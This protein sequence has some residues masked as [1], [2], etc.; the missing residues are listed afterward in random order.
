MN[1]QMTKQ[2]SKKVVKKK[3]ARYEYWFCFVDRNNKMQST[4]ADC[5]CLIN[6]REA[7][8][9]AQAEIEHIVNGNFK[10]FVNFK[11]LRKKFITV[12]EQ[13]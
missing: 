2:T 12:E 1:K 6:S 5:V 11:L 4:L 9:Q 8:L 13:K 7:L 10:C 3:K